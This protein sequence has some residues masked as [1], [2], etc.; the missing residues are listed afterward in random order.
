MAEMSDRSGGRIGPIA[1][2]VAVPGLP[3]KVGIRLATAGGRSWLA[4]SGQAVD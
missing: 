4:Q 2:V 3:T 1:P